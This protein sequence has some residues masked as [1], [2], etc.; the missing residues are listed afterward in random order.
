MTAEYSQVELLTI[1]A[2]HEIDLTNLD[3]ALLKQ[4][5]LFEEITRALPQLRQNTEIAKSNRDQV[6]AALSLQFRDEAARS[7]KKTTEAGIEAEILLAE[8]YQNAHEEYLQ[9][10]LAQDQVERARDVMVQREGAIKGLIT[11]YAQGYWSIQGTE[12]LPEP[13]NTGEQ[14]AFKRRP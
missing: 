1:E 6:R 5:S 10:R 2:A 4:A 14:K 11:L 9:A 7:G 8:T 3:Q 13:R 12:S